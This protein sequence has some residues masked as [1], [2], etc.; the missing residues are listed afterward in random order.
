[1]LC[2]GKSDNLTALKAG[3]P[4]RNPLLRYGDIPYGRYAAML[5]EPGLSVRTFG[6]GKRLLLIPIKGDALDAMLNGRQALMVHAGALNPRY[7]SWEGLRPTHGCIRM[8]EKDLEQIIEKMAG[9]R[10]YVN[11]IPQSQGTVAV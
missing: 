2:L 9:K 6:A 4:D 1:M 8:F 10:C 3:N 11:V 7:L 5:V